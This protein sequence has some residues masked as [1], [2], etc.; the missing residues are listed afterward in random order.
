MPYGVHHATEVETDALAEGSTIVSSFQVGRFALH[1]ASAMGW[2]TSTNG[3]QTWQNGLLPGVS[4]ASPNPNST[5]VSVANQS[6]LYD[7]AHGTWLIPTVGVVNCANEVP[8]TASCFGQSAGEHSL[9]V[10]TSSDGLNWSQ[11]VVAVTSNVD[12]PWGVCDN[13]PS[14][15]FYGTCYVA[16]GQID[17]G[18]RLALVRTTDGGQTWS[19]PIETT[20]DQN[21]YNA[22]P[23]VQPDGR[24]V[25]VATDAGNGSN[26]SLL[27]SFISNDGGA[28]LSDA[29]TGPNALPAIQYH[30]PAGGIRAKDKPSVAVDSAGTVYVAWSDCRFR[31]ACAENDIVMATSTDGMNFSAPIRVAEDPATST[32][33]HFIPGIGVRPGTSG[34]SAE[35]GVVNYFYPAANCTSSTCRLDVEFSSSINGGAQWTTT[36]LNPTPM[37]LSWLAPTTLGPAVGDYES[38]TYSQGQAVTVFPLASAPVS[39]TFDEAEN[40]ATMPSAGGSP[41]TSTAGAGQIEEAG[42]TFPTPFRATVVNPT[43]GAAVVGAPVTFSAPSTGAGGTFAGGVTS[44]VTTSNGSGVATAPAFTANGTPGTYT[45]MAA[46]SGGSTGFQTV[47]AGPPAT[48]LPLV[49]TS[50][51][52]APVGT[53]YPTPATVTVRDVNGVPVSGATVVFAAPSAGASGT[54][55]PPGSGTTATVVTNASG[56]AVAPTFTA[57]ATTGSYVLT[58]TAGSA[59]GSVSMTNTSSAPATLTVI[60]G[61]GQSATIGTSFSTPLTVTLVDSSGQPYPG[62]AVTF[63]APSART[64]ATFVA[65]GLTTTTVT[66]DATGTATVPTAYASSGSGTYTVSVSSGP[67]SASISLTNDAGPPVYVSPWASTTNQSQQVGGAY[68]QQLKVTVTDAFSNPVVAVPVTFT[69]PSSGPSGTFAGSGT[70]ATIITNSLGQASSPVLTANQVPGAFQV[71]VTAASGSGTNP[72]SVFNLTNTQQPAI[73]SPGTATFGVGIPDSFTVTSTGTPTPSLSEMGALPPGVF[74]TDAGNGTATIAGTPT[75]TGTFPLTVSSVER[76]RAGSSGELR[77]LR[78]STADGHFHR[79]DFRFDDRWHHCH[80]YRLGFQRGHGG[81]LRVDPGPGLHRGL[82]HRGDGHRA[83]R[84]GQ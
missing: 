26:G 35:I 15:P 13:S 49:G 59:V 61:S 3:G 58:V 78:Q 47:N 62:A 79:T 11:P 4:A 73:T 46:T 45:V 17:D 40:A 19:A 51:L 42:G 53:A 1:G 60:G 69:A 27:L 63:T 64:S 20:S 70:S 9:L 30:T 50:P 28:T 55:A 57:N 65:T 39:G 41:I 44:V 43:T 54:F 48:V 14:S 22:I 23:V 83:G 68:A 2:A 34:T 84:V 52:G 25:I 6:V 16:Y 31:T 32:D 74:F 71:G 36:Q 82:R 21:A 24:L 67:A 80:D 66:T 56:I 38:V 7:A 5:Y 37:Q 8:T 10:N 72:S 76:D 77:P 75:M 33:D 29:V 12:K 18:E 81:R